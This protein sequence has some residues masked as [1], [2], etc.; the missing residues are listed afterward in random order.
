MFASTIPPVLDLTLLTQPHSGSGKPIAFSD[1]DK[2]RQLALGD[3][4]DSIDIS[5]LKI[6]P[7]KTRR[8]PDHAKVIR[9]A[10][11]AL[12]KS[13]KDIETTIFLA[14]AAIS[15][16]G[17]PGLRDVLRLVRRYHEMRWDELRPLIE[18]PKPSIRDAGLRAARVSQLANRVTRAVYQMPVTGASGGGLGWSWQSQSDD[19]EFVKALRDTGLERLQTISQGLSESLLECDGDDAIAPIDQLMRDKYEGLVDSDEIPTFREV[20]KAAG[21]ALD[22]V[23][24]TISARGGRLPGELIVDTRTPLTEP[25]G[26]IRVSPGGGSAIPQS[27]EEALRTILAIV[28]WLES[29]EPQNLYTGRIREAIED[30]D[31]SVQDVL[32][33]FIENESERQ[34]VTKRLGHMLNWGRTV[35]APGALHSRP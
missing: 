33:K 9:L 32:A 23:N 22:F 27:R 13:P 28:K 3:P 30:A 19:V 16:H 26:P 31:C 5:G 12:A 15:S 7:R 1:L 35:A 6:D 14:E 34:A 24:D 8:L 29:H 20:R 18:M 2:I 25:V 4:E 11:T 21:E 17:G 10:T